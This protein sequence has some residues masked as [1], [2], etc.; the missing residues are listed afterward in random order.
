MKNSCTVK[1]ILRKDKKKKNGTCPLYFSIIINSNQLRIPVGYSISPQDWDF[2]KSYPNGK[3]FGSL[4]HLL[5]KKEYEIKDYIYGL[6]LSDQII[7]FQKVKEYC[8]GNVNKD[9]YHYFDDFTKKKFDSISEGTQ[10]HYKLLRKQL[11]EYK[12]QLTL[13]EIGYSFLKD[14]FYHLK[15][16]KLIG[17]SG[18]GMRRKN[19]VT[20]F[21]EFIKLGLVSRNYAKELPRFKENVREVFLTSE[22]LKALLNANL[23]YGVKTDGLKLTRDIFLFSCYT[24]LRYS[25]VINL[26][27][28]SIKEKKICL[29]MQKTKKVV[30]IPLKKEALS[31]LNK[32]NYKKKRGVIFPFRCNVS[33]N[34][35]LKI[36]ARKAA[37]EKVLTFHA[38]RHTFGSI[39]AFNGVQPFYIMKLMG[40]GD[41]RMTSRYVNSD[42]K[43]LNDVM[44]KVSF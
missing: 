44:Q 22:E 8:N 24:G 11:K 23:T 34:R 43:I 26:K 12:T 37:I 3:N 27:T 25:D 14:F 10:G 42:S 5:S 30:E 7:T 21:E 38:S 28:D 13:K 39:L 19:L 35:D 18:L 32:Y 41:V 1:T 20:M 33:V 15:H 9:F 31:L 29:E 16:K 6:E 17:D 36:I 4:K 40:H 2:D